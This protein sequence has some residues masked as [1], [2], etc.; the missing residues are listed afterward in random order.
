M[1][2][3]N[4][5]TTISIDTQN[6]AI[7]FYSMVGN[8]KS[9]II[10]NI[11]SFS[12]GKLDEQFFE[13]F[14]R[15]V[16]KFTEK[17]PSKTVR[18]V[19]VILPDNAVLTDTVKVPTVKGSGQMQKMLDVTLDGLYKNYNDL[20]IIAHTADQNKQYSTI[21]IAAVQNEII[22]S[23]YAA[24]SENKVLVDTL[25]FASASTVAGATLFNPKLKNASYVFL[26]IKDVYS[27]FIF[28]VNGKVM[29][30]YTLPFGLEFL[31][32]PKVVQED[33]LFN[34]A[35]AELAVVN[36]REKA[37]S[38]KLSVMDD[39]NQ[40]PEI[41]E[42]E[43]SDEDLD[44]FITV[45]EEEIAE[46]I[47]EEIEE[48]V[49]EEVNANINVAEKA[50]LPKILTRKSPRNLP[51]FMLRQK[52][53]TPEQTT[54]ENFRVFV[55]WALTLIQG[56]E[57]ITELGKPHFVC[58]NLPQNLSFVVDMVNKEIQENG[59]KFTLLHTGDTEKTVREHL[60]LYGGLYP[61]QINASNKF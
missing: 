42:N 13:K 36:A 6:S 25:T 29:G 27:K 9:T 58:V 47:E 43:E 1:A 32:K 41:S 23:I 39:I 51:K 10:H 8:D 2:K 38:K 20:H 5:S 60:E 35:Y 15:S 30:F 19:T 53:E 55:K 26:D 44:E 16:R 33:M 7:H 40:I 61:N 3:S 21:A 28:V 59:I 24:C 17:T 49:T 34:H 54:Y 14:K 22:S 52:P 12:S 45:A 56:N 11:K 57:K 48:E 18:K 31:R 50:S 37:K 46:E 4:Y